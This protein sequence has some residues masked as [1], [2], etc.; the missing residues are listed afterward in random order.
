M[1][2]AD[3]ED[4]ATRLPRFWADHPKGRIATRL[5]S[6]ATTAGERWIVK[7]CLYREGETA[8][9]SEG[10][11]FEVDGQGNV[12]KT[13]ALENCETSAIGRA[14]AN[15]GYGARDKPRASREE[16]AKVDRG[17]TKTLPPC[18]SCKGAVAAFEDGFACTKCDWQT[19][20]K[21]KVA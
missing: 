6:E 11:A 4:V 1:A 16:M 21:P 15:A 13:S 14:L 5:L 17:T 12:N 3:Y 2:L 20:E 19:A 7:A 10:Y 18:P 9:F 8:P